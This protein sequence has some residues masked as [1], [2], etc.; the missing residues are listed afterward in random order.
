M[1]N[2]ANSVENLVRDLLTAP[3][4]GT[5]RTR[6]TPEAPYAAPSPVA[7]GWT[8][9]AGKDLPRAETDVLVGPHLRDAL[10][11]LNPSIA[12][13]PARADEVIYRLR[14]ILLSVGGDGLVKANEEF[15]SWLRGE[16]T[17]PFGEKGQHVAIR[18]LD[19][20][21][22]NKNRLVLST[23]VTYR[24]QME[25]RFDLVLWANGIP[26]VVGEAK[27]PTRNS[28]SWVDGALQVHDDY[29]KNVTAFFVPNVFSFATEGKTF[30]FGSIRMPVELWAPW[31]EEGDAAAPTGLAEVRTAV[32]LLL[33]PEVVLDI[34]E[35]FTVFATDSKHQKIKV[36][37]RFQQYYTVNQIV[38]RVVEGRIKKGLIWH[39]QGS[40]KSILMVFAALKLRRQPALKAPTV[41]I[42]VDR[43]DL[44]T[45]ITATFNATDVPNVVAADSREKLQALLAGDV[46]KVLITTIHKF[47]ESDGVLNARD[48]V[49]LLADEC[50]RTQEGDL[51]RKMREA[52]PNA[53]LFGLTGTPINKKDRNTFWAFG[54]DEDQGGYMSRYSFEQS[55]RDHATLPLHFEARS[56]ELRVD[57]AAI[58]QAFQ[59]ITGRLSGSD[60]AN[61][62]K[63]A[64]KMGALV[65]SPER[66]RAVA[67][68]IAEHFLAKV[69][70]DGFKAQVVVYDQES[71]VL[72]KEAL[73]DFLPADASTV[74]ISVTG[75]E[76]D[77]RL[78]AYKRDRDQEE[79]LLDR[80]RDPKDPLQILIVTAKLLMGFDAPILQTMYL[81]KPIKEHSL[82]QAICRTNR[83]Y[84]GKT[85][86][87]I[88]DY[89]GIF[90]EV[91][92]ALAF[93]EKSVQQVITNLEELKVQVP[94]RMA[95]C[96]AYFPDVDRTVSGYEGL[97]AAQQCLPTD[98]ERDEFGK[99]FSGLNQLWEALSPDPCLTGFA[100]D[101]RW[102]SQ[103]YESIKPP[104]GNGKLVWHA[105]GAKTTELIH[106]NVHVQAVRDDLETLVMNPEILESIVAG[107]GLGKAKEIEVVISERLRR[108]QG[109]PRF[110]ALGQRLEDLRA[111]FDQRLLNSMEFLKLL[112]AIAREV[113]EAE[114]QVQPAEEQDLAKNALTELFQTVKTETTPIIVERIVNDVDEIVRTVR[115][116]GWQTTTAGEREVKRALRRVLLKYKLQTEQELFDKAYDYIRQ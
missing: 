2:E 36:I 68:D 93:D 6:E 3:A 39:F 13:Q 103:V 59:A 54:A 1:F 101:Y 66:V 14:A 61:L 51:G 19:L 5:T 56:V 91:A 79:R 48:N 113:L 82:L 41:I 43:I 83:P 4:V 104:S 114:Q 78:L 32:S 73:D 75:S 60:A 46:R 21:S 62:S 116:A 12:A 35:S 69:Q 106:E 53:F 100:A 45:Q 33:R 88:V 27:T 67:K 105:L 86:G 90:D 80:F 63:E 38:Q 64:G 87:L 112:L 20:D 23:Q 8:F 29:E 102:L 57:K 76:T 18:L 89:L 98:D 95:R 7:L 109:D 55:I 15:T 22:P 44:D 65:K 11:A 34:L 25:R 16:K 99:A 47:A 10:L 107:G 24:A 74:V 31:R 28:V 30:R 92:Q 26:L 52:L 77:P 81:D 85:F 70:P 71:C 17:M 111:R 84:T 58:N 108:H 50:H 115:F 97:L 37:C 94:E 40:G 96:L 9:T 110:V 72:Y 42:V 49:I